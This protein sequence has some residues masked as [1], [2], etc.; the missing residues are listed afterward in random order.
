MVRPV[1][2]AS[3]RCVWAEQLWLEGWDSPETSLETEASHACCWAPEDHRHTHQV[4]THTCSS[5]GASVKISLQHNVMHTQLRLWLKGFW[6]VSYLVI[7]CSCLYLVLC[8]S[9][10]PA[11]LTYSR[12]IDNQ[13]LLWDVTQTGGFGIPLHRGKS[14]VKQSKLNLSNKPINNIWTQNE[15]TPIT[16]IFYVILA[17]HKCTVIWKCITVWIERSQNL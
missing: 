13:N 12:N 8:T 7:R 11:E 3:V 5:L 16:N 14:L 2:A 15:M 17:M 1:P 4:N 9:Y 10:D 6:T